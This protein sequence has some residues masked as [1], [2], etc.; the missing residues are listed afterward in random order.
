M[1]LNKIGIELKKKE[2]AGVREMASENSEKEVAEEED[3]K[4]DGVWVVGSFV[5]FS[6]IFLQ[7]EELH[8]F[9]NQQRLVNLKSRHG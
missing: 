7:G 8:F 2:V 1:H 6:F 3:V 5:W 9:H 4:G